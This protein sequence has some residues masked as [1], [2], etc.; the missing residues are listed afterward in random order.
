MQKLYMTKL[1][2]AKKTA[3]S[4]IQINQ[5]KQTLSQQLVLLPAYTFMQLKLAACTI[6][7]EPIPASEELLSQLLHRHV[8]IIASLPMASGSCPAASAIDIARV[9]SS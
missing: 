8:S 6:T 4:T 3:N 7:H 1:T 9:S 2:R 5:E